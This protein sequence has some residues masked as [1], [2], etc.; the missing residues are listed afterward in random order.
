MS[1]KKINNSQVKKF[2]SDVAKLKA[3]GLVSNRV[4]AR[5]Q[6]ETRYMK[7]QVK[8]FADVLEGKAKAV[9][10]SKRGEAKEFS[11]RFLTKGKTV[12]IPLTSKDEKIRYNKSSHSFSAY[13]K[14]NDKRVIR[15]IYSDNSKVKPRRKNQLFVIPLGNSRQSFDT[16]GDL[17]LFM[18]PYENNPKNPYKEW[19]KYVEIVTIEGGESDGEE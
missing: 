4:D 1:S 5:S 10:V 19:A 7:S 13:R 9:K 17:V 14:V 3:A 8:K 11:D 15:D 6:R 16:W 12:V 2:R 18:E